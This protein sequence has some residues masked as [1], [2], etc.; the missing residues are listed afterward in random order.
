[1]KLICER[2]AILPKLESLQNITNTQT[3]MPILNNILIR[4]E[5]PDQIMLVGNNLEA[6]L[7]VMVPATIS[8]PGMASIPSRRLYEMIREM[9]AGSTFSL[10]VDDK[11]NVRIQYPLGNYR[12]KGLD[13]EEFPKIPEVKDVNQKIKGH[14]LSNL[15][16][17]TLFAAP[18]GGV[19]Y[20]LNGIN[21]D[22]AFDEKTGSNKMVTAAAETRRIAIGQT[23]LNDDEEYEEASFIVPSKSARELLNI[24]A[25][26]E[27]VYYL[28]DESK[29]IVTDKDSIFITQLIDGAFPDYKRIISVSYDN[30]IFVNKEE[31]ISAIKRVDLVADPNTFSMMFVIKDETITLQVKTPDIGEA[32]T[33]VP[34]VE[35]FEGEPA[36]FRFNSKVLIEG[37][38][39]I[40]TEHVT[41]IF[42]TLAQHIYLYPD[43]ESTE[44]SYF[45]LVMPLVLKDEEAAHVLA[46]IEEENPIGQPS[47]FEQ[48][49]VEEK[50]EEPKV[51]PKEE[52]PEDEQVEMPF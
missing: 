3:S 8:E 24:F 20:S 34:L 41:V 15:L 42:G 23:L 17:S 5:E 45:N 22:V 40:R 32:N 26:S 2:D 49:E 19:N 27:E 52:E 48:P 9:P 33:V 16:E 35:P 36:V 6:A 4:Q 30:D 11:F 14:E 31:L 29:L 38:S 51:E 43:N 25:S 21:F 44:D 18:V 1:M 47:L 39:Q 10:S 28:L 7:G 46:T 13:P 12:L 37:L 50:K